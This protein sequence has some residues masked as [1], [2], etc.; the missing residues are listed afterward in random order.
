LGR[1]PI[2]DSNSNTAKRSGSPKSRFIV[3]LPRMSSG[4]PS[5]L[6]SPTPAAA[7]ER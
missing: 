7:T 2:C 4:S 5:L 6:L 3:L 1:K